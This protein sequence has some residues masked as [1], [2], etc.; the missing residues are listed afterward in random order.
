MRG[1]ME[2]GTL[3]YQCWALEEGDDCLNYASAPKIASLL[4]SGC[5]LNYYP[6]FWLRIYAPA[7]L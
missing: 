7:A 6:L 2:G 4:R 5:I 1:A 3:L